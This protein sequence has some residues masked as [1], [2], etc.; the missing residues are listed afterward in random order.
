MSAYR[1]PQIRDYGGLID[2]TANDLLSGG[3]HSM[4]LAAISTP[5]FP[6]SSG[7]SSVPVANTPGGGGDPGGGDPGGGGGGGNVPGGPGPV[8]P[9]ASHG[10]AH[11]TGGGDGNL[12]GIAGAGP[13]ATAGGNSSLP[14][15]GFAVGAVAA[16]GS[17]FAAS[18]ALIRR[19]ARR[20]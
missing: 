20:H 7:E 17:A 5:G 12:P 10:S 16:L 19:A 18:G 1:K 8:T 11:S 9:L 6:N 13:H 2:L 3:L 4:P 14:F 15:T